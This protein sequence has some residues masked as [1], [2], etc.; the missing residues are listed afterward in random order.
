MVGVGIGTIGAIAAVLLLMPLTALAP[1]G[2]VVDAKRGALNEAGRVIPYVQFGDPTLRGGLLGVVTPPAGSSASA[3][4][5]VASPGNALVPAVKNPTS[6]QPVAQITGL[7]STKAHGPA[8]DPSIAVSGSYLVEVAGYSARIESPSGKTVYSNFTLASFFNLSATDSFYYSHVIFDS[9]SDRWL[10]STLDVTRNAVFF[11][12]SK[13]TSPLGAFYAYNVVATFGSGAQEYMDYT[14]WGVSATYWALGIDVWNSSTTTFVGNA[15]ALFGQVKLDSGTFL[16][17]AISSSDLSVTPA[18]AI[19]TNASGTPIEYAVSTVAYASSTSLTVYEYT[20]LVPHAAVTSVTYTISSTGNLPG[21]PQPGTGTTLT[22][23]ADRVLSASWSWGGLT[24]W[25]TYTTACTPA[26][27]STLRSCVR[28]DA[29]NT[30]SNSLAQDQDLG[31]AGMYLFGASLTALSNGTGFLMEFGDTGG[32][33]YPSLALTGQ[34]TTDPYG[35]F[36][37]PIPVFTGTSYD[38]TGFGEGSTD[39]Q[40]V[41]TTQG[42]AWSAGATDATTGWQTEIVHYTF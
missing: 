24:L 6:P 21:I 3:A 2:G 19:S 36:R 10:I 18:I 30:V 35:S 14:Q 13:T 25:V 29:V 40:F 38:A 1:V 17:Q 5:V 27:D 20:G 11:S 33:T 9:I 42:T 41:Q 22:T 7:N 37:G 28:V 12:V 39:T 23:F 16:A 15:V 32:L 26:G 8:G 31:V 34:A 4:P